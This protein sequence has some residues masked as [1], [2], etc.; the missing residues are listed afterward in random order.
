MIDHSTP[1][2]LD[3]K[4]QRL[5]T[6]TVIVD[7]TRFVTNVVPKNTPVYDSP[8]DHR[9]GVTPILLQNEQRTN[10]LELSDLKGLKLRTWELTDEIGN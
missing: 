7:V 3:K 9:N 4:P 5:L 6:L 2:D 8:A 10:V 1:I